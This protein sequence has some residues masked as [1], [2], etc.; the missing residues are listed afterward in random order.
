MVIHYCG[1]PTLTIYRTTLNG[2]GA[3]VYPLEEM[4]AHGVWT[5]D[6][7]SFA[8][9]ATEYRLL[10][11]GKENVM[12][13]K[14]DTK[15]QNEYEVSYLDEYGFKYSFT[16]YMHRED[17]VI[18]PAEGMQISQLSDML[19]TK[20]GVQVVFTEGARCTYTLNNEPEKVYNADEVL[21]KDGTYRFRVVDKAGNV[22]TYTVKKDSAVEYRLEGAGVNEILVNGGVTNSNT[23]RFYAENADNAYIKKVFLNNEFI[24]YGDEVFT[25]RGK[26]ELIVAD[27]AGN[28][29][30]F[31]FYILYGKIDGFKYAAPYNYEITSV[32]HEIGDSTADAS[33]TIQDQGLRL[34]A[35]ENGKY[36]VTMRST[37]TGST[38]SFTFTID[39]TPPSVELLG[40][41]V[42]EKTINNITFK[43]VSVGDTLYVY[44]DG[45]LTRTVRIDSDYMD[46]PTISEAG[47]YRIVIENEA[48][49]QTELSFERKYIPNVAGNILIIVLAMASVAGLFVGL[50]WRNHSKTDD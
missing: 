38:K 45:V 49:V 25:E 19:V 40:C 7:V 36:T 29:S 41:E 12:S 34:E 20:D 10:V 22:S 13:I 46:P 8:I 48:G 21:Y 18:Q 33:E 16:V 27:D 5:N 30:Y 35:S 17:V 47:K 50:I 2:V 14:Y 28:E 3:E 32:I 23:V 43:G 44:R 11:D 6:S 39:K 9:S 26:W 1:T 15:T 4:L 31:R 24:E 37:V 42:G